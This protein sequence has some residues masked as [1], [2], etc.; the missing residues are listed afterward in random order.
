MP[1]VEAGGSAREQNAECPAQ[2]PTGPCACEGQ[3]CDYREP[4]LQTTATCRDGVWE[5]SQI[6]GNPPPFESCPMDLPSGGEACNVAPEDECV[7]AWC[8]EFPSLEARCDS[9]R[10]M[11]LETSCNPPPPCADNDASVNCCPEQLPEH[12]SECSYLGEPCL[13]LNCVGYLTLE[14]ACVDGKWSVDADCLL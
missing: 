11:I 12:D 7:Y 2:T 4:Y 5:L 3:V 8:G 9:G 1:K 6:I 14:A 13:Y 10:W